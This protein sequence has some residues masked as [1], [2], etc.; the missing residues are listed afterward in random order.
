MRSIH[1]VAGQGWNLGIKDIQTLSKILDQY[2][3]DDPIVEQ[4]Y[5]SRRNIESALYLNFT[6]FLNFLY[7]EEKSFK[8]NMVKLG[9]NIL[10]IDPIKNLFIRQ[11]MG[12]DKLI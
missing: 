2:P 8:K 4:I 10:N 5:F 9:F 11:A 6:S 7:E 3:L 12:R 1:P